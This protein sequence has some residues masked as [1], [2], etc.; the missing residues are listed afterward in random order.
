MNKD[1]IRI[2]NNIIRT[3]AFKIS[4]TPAKNRITKHS[5]RQYKDT[6]RISWNK[7]ERVPPSENTLSINT[8]SIFEELSFL[9]M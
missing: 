9:L 4:Y 2:T 8:Y 5:L 1:T 7:K 3:Y 6:L